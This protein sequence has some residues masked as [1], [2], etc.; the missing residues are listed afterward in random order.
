MKG[1]I[2]N[3]EVLQQIATCVCY[4]GGTVHKGKTFV[5]VIPYPG[6]KGNKP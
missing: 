5:K 6:T 3:P 4:K 2:T 1:P